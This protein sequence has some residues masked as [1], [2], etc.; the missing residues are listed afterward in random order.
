MSEPKHITLNLRPV[1]KP[2]RLR[3][4]KPQDPVPIGI[5]AAL[6]GPPGPPGKDG[7]GSGPPEIEWKSTNW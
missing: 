7:L 2:I 3:V 5:R 1:V 6:Q 4:S